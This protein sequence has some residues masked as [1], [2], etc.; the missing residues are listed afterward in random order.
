M[1]SREHEN[2]PESVIENVA[3]HMVNEMLRD[4]LSLAVML[5]HPCCICGS[6]SPIHACTGEETNAV[7]CKKLKTCDM[8]KCTGYEPVERKREG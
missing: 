3:K 6:T 8:I 1:T 5:S 4:A 7:P 2:V